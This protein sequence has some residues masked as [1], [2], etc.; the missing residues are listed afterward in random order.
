[1]GRN[2]L[3]E[4]VTHVGFSSSKGHCVLKVNYRRKLN[5]HVSPT[6]YLK[7]LTTRSDIDWGGESIQNECSG[8]LRK[9][10]ETQKSES[11]PRGSD[12]QGSG[13][14]IITLAAN[15]IPHQSWSVNQKNK[16]VQGFLSSEY[17]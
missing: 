13:S 7:T 17:T 10:G 14:V 15:A 3:Q 2:S 8:N 11:C 5:C 4:A 16:C 1:M 9:P 12:C 6:C